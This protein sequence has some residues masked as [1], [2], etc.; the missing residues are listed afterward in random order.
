MPR[1]DLALALLLAALTGVSR[2]P[3]RAGVL[4]SW[5]AV[6][7]ALSLHDYDVV[8]HQPHPPGY[9]LYVGLGR[10]V[11]A[12][13]RDA[14]ASLA[15]LALA[16]SVVTVIL[17]YRLAWQLWGRAT[18]VVA[19][20]ALAASPLFWFYGLVGLPY[21]TEAALA[22]AVAASIW[23]MRGGGRRAVFWSAVAL[24]TAG[25]VRQSVLLLLF[26]LWLGMAW[27]GRRD[28]RGVGLGLGVLGLTTAAWLVPM[29]WLSGGPVRYVGAGLELFQSTV[30]ATTVLGDWRL[31]LVALLEGLLL[32][33]G[34]L[35]P[36]AIGI[37]L[38]GLPRLGQRDPRAWF[39]AGWVVPPLL[40]YAFVHFGQYGYL[41]TVL[42][43]LYVVVARGLVRAASRLPASG[44]GR[45]ALAVLL[46]A[47]LLGHA[48]FVTLAG[49]PDVP[50]R[51]AEAPDADG[52]ASAL[53]ARYRFRLW[54]HTVRGLR[55]QEAVIRAYVEGV[56]REFDPRDTVLVTELGNPR[57]YPWFRHAMYYLPEY[58]VYHLRVGR[59]SPGWLSSRQD[60]MVVSLGGP[61]VLLPSG[62]RRLVWVVDHWSPWLP[63]PPGLRAR[64]LPHGRWLYVLDLERRPVEHG[65]YRLT[66][67]TALARLR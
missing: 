26:P 3:F 35:L 49:A 60:G 30:R 45:P 46:A 27:D 65:G 66:P 41:L 52:W 22:T 43:A 9:I 42:P 1:T 55:E 11:D 64:P 48:G 61:E 38:A 32:G 13:A 5:D 58:A 25:G 21:T 4:P 8:R 31:N 50:G 33:L 40:V 62:A 36:V 16:A 19:A 57:S 28:R 44:P 63:P 14:T 2:V 51:L 23:W 29:V 17:V 7:F 47:L 56:R 6:Q 59:Q 24:G 67:L 53:R 37:V 54:P 20:G 10:L 12:V 34:A 15:W 18:A 39:F